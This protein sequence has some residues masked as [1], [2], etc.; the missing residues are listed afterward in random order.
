MPNNLLITGAAGFI[1]S[2]FVRYWLNKHPSDK[3]TALDLL[4][5]AGRQ[6]SLSGLDINF[7]R[8][9][10]C[11]YEVIANLMREQSIDRIIH[12]A[13]E[14]HVDRSIEKPDVFLETNIFGTHSLLKAARA[15]WQFENQQWR[16]NTHFHFV[17]TDEVFGSLGETSVA[18]K[19]SNAFAPSSPYAAT[20]AAANHLVRS[21]WQTYGLPATISNCSNNYG[22]FQFPEKLIPR[23][24]INILLGRRL[25]IFGAGNQIRDWLFVDD[26]CQ[27]I[28][29]IISLGTKGESYNVGAHEELSNLTVTHCICDAVDKRFRANPTL[30][31]QFPNC[32]SARLEKPSSL[33]SHVPDR[34]GHDKRYAI[35]A[36]K[37]KKQLGFEPSVS[38]AQGIEKT[39]E[40]YLSNEQ[41][42]RSVAH[43]LN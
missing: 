28:D 26:H 34:L 35:D 6:D 7:V 40:W 32:P 4:T 37:L 31:L 11:D 21:Y 36:S 29:R 14:T 16:G 19:E 33:I 1:G 12:F 42:W 23:L 2:N 15:N 20:K 3:V 10:V 25:P 18:F 43:E 13:A 5:Y 27:A 17:S 38:F 9:N 24:I 41:W 22:P 39:I 8:A 30:R